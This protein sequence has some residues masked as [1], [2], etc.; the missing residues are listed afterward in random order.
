MSTESANNK[1]LAKN[2][3]FLYFRMFITLLVGL[4]TSRVVLN[5][6]GVTDYGIYNVLGGIVAIFAT[7][8]NAM[9]STSCRYITFYLGRGE[10]NKLKQIFSTVTY[11]HFAIACVVILICET[12]GLWFFYNHMSIPP[13]RVDVAFWLLQF[14]FAAS[15]LS[16]INIPYTG[17]IIA[18]ENM[19][20]YAY[21][22]IFD[23]IMKLIIVFLIQVTPADKLLSYGFLILV[24]QAI[25]FI[26]YRYYC[27]RKY[28]ES[29]LIL[30]FDTK[31]FKELSSYFG[32][33]ILGNLAVVF[34]TQGINLLLNVFFGPAI[35]AARGVAVQVQHII[36]QFVNNF[37]VALNPQI[38]KSYAN[39]ELDRM[40]QLMY[41]SSKYGFLLLFI[42][43]FPVMLEADYILHLWLGNVPSYSD[44]FLR[45][46]LMSCMVNALANSSTVAAGATGKIKT[47]SIVVGGT[48]LIPLP[49]AYVV[50]HFIE[51][52]ETVFWVVLFFEVLALY[53]RLL[54]MR[55]MVYLS[56]SIYFKKVIMPVIG[57]VISVIILPVLLHNI[58]EQSFINVVFMI[59][60]SFLL[61]L[62]AVY[63]I[64]LSKNERS[65][66]L[67]T[68][69]SKVLHKE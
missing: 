43:S 47:Y 9:S 53:L 3:L 18:H 14:S 64:G 44:D 36:N 49:V 13:E 8:N 42:L 66:V 27:V 31:L 16:M 30:F 46:I 55:K 52:P 35:N 4:Y 59:G 40:H 62:L 58:L 45:I 39:E 23:V 19:N 54:F 2:T 11:V 50:L 7:L 1:R 33:S 38:V 57:V 65:F 34:N 67:K 51:K 60:L 10:N 28:T 25:D 32:W 63:I 12:V 37:Q 61:S 41:A 56:L 24:V 20:I 17:L 22:S 15:F 29:H 68:I 26:I 21:I 5:V 69:K 6:L 48:V